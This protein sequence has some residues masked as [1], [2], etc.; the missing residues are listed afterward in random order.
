M[1]SP[2]RSGRPTS[3]AS[4]RSK[5]R[6]SMGRTLYLTASVM[7]RSWSSFSLA[8]FFAARS[9]TRLKSVRVS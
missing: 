5:I 8:G 1:R 6:S 7:K 2:I 4:S 3:F 9:F